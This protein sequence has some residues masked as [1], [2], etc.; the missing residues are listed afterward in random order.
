MTQHI[1]FDLETLGLAHDALI[2]SIGAVKFN[3]FSGELGDTFHRVIDL[4]GP[5][6]VIDAST[7]AWWMRQSDE[8]R[9][10]IFG[11]DVERV[12]LGVALC[13]FSE[14]IGFTEELEDGQYPDVQLWARGNKDGQW[15]ESAYK[16]IGFKAPFRYWQVADQRT[17]TNAF[18]MIVG[19][20]VDRAQGVAHNAL[21]DAV[22]QA[23][24]LNLVYA[25]L[26]H[27]GLIQVPAEK[28]VEAPVSAVVDVEVLDDEAEALRQRVLANGY[29]AGLTTV[30]EA[31]ALVAEV[32]D[33]STFVAV[34]KAFVG[35]Q[36]DAL[37]TDHLDRDKKAEVDMAM[38]GEP[39]EPASMP[40]PLGL[41]MDN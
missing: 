40:Q 20:H 1:S 15:L 8:A 36:G 37:I 13:E 34:D 39:Y 4:D 9:N 22:D 11:K 29:A 12:K 19:N 30:V 23:K 28:P 25:H 33:D 10:A 14:W 21:T 2:L 31:V 18:H 17:M 3:P 38:N 24:E 5:G 35:V 26:L 27:A 41:S 16:G 7:V 32:D 6:G